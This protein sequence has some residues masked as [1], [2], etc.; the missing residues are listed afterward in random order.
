[1]EHEIRSVAQLSVRQLVEGDSSW[2]SWIALVKSARAEAGMPRSRRLLA[3]LSM[4]E[5]SLK[6]KAEAESFADLNDLAQWLSASACPFDQE[7]ALQ[8]MST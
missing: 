4:L 5:P 7:R 8:R 1:M 6:R 3:G 2:K